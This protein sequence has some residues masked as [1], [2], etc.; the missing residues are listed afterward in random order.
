MLNAWL[1]A[2]PDIDSANLA[3]EVAERFRIL[4]RQ[5]QFHGSPVANDQ[6]EAHIAKMVPA[7][8]EQ[9]VPQWRGLG[10]LQ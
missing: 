10:V 5:L 3:K 9:T 6:L 1:S 2:G 8:V 4:G 7:F